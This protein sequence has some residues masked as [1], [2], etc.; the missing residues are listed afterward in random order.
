MLFIILEKVIVDWI[1]KQILDGLQ[2]YKC[3]T[4]IS[5]ER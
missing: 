1:G 2:K 5:G 4:I 3:L